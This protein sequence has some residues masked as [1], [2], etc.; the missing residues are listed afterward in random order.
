[1]YIL[2]LDLT[3]I[4]IYF[5]NYRQFLE[6][7]QRE[8]FP[9]SAAESFGGHLK[10]ADEK[11]LRAMDP[12]A[13]KGMSAKEKEEAL[14]MPNRLLESAGGAAPGAQRPGQ[15]VKDEEGNLKFIPRYRDILQR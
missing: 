8:G 5:M 9:K 11:R 7:S 3:T 4:K 6:K 1:M 13:S 12:N 15:F 14:N 2:I 10:Q